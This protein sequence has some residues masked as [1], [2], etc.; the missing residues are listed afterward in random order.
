MPKTISAK[1]L[2]ARLGEVVEKVVTSRVV[3]LAPLHGAGC[4]ASS[5]YSGMPPR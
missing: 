1:E 4:F 5:A 2:R 3:R